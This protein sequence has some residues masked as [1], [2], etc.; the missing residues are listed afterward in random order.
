MKQ[1]FLSLFFFLY[2]CTPLAYQYSP[3]V[4][5]HPSQEPVELDIELIPCN[6]EELK[7]YEEQGWDAYECD[8]DK[9]ERIY[10]SK[11]QRKENK[12]ILH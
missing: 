9:S 1:L 6:E 7:Y 12:E 4:W 10:D 2:A 11:A 5:L 8:M 3:E